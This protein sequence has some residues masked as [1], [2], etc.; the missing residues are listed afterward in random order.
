VS[1]AWPIVAAACL[2]LA[3]AVSAW[4]AVS[5]WEERLA[6]AK[7]T[8][9]AGDYASVLQNGLDDFLGK[10][11]ALRA[12]YDSS[13][14][15]DSAEFSLFTSQINREHGDVM[16]LIWCPRVSR[17]ERAEFERK[18]RDGGLT[19][20]AIRTW[21]LTSPVSVSPE[22]DD[23]FPI[24]Y[25]TV[26]SQKSATLGTDLNSERARSEA[27]KRA[28][29]GNIMATAQNILLRNPIGGQRPGFFAVLPVYR[30]GV[31]H[32]T[33]D[34]RRENTLG[35][36][37]GAFQ[38]AAVF[39]AILN[40]AILPKSVDLYLYPSQAGADALPVYMRGAVGSD[41]PIEAKPQEA[42]AGLPYW[43]TALNVGDASWDLVVVPR[44]AG[45]GSFYRAWLVLAAVL[46]AFGA[47]L[48]YMWAS[49]R[50]ALR[51]ETAN[52]RILELAQ[53]DLLTNLATAAPSPSGCPWPLPR[54]GAA[55]RPSP[56]S[57]STSITSRT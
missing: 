54:P 2:G 3:V 32:S 53:T 46:L 1:H 18:Q 36:I 27:I 31:P 13:V 8:A 5:I 56:C 10:I 34:E 20:Y 30:K 7:F 51:L 28:R 35:L 22:R 33:V 55:L 26:A 14:E 12:F 40:K 19:G 45:L 57:I 43:S 44:Q 29:A 17:D 4:F 52:S 39:D 50:H 6:R 24:L 37:A 16:R 42:L 11:L 21:S 41:Q 15:V 38:T 47:L 25:S 49:L 48:A 23:Y 9:V